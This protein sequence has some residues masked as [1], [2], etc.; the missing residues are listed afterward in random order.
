[1][2]SIDLKSV[3]LTVRYGGVGPRPRKKRVHSKVKTGCATCRTRRV[4]CDETKPACN[5][6]TKGKRECPGYHSNI[7][8]FQP[9]T[10]TSRS[11]SLAASTVRPPP[12]FLPFE[13]AAG[14]TSFQYYFEVT[15]QHLSRFF[16]AMMS[17]SFK[18]K[19]AIA[20][21][22]GVSSTFWQTTFPRLVCAQPIVRQGL[23]AMTVAHRRL[24]DTQVPFTTDPDSLKV[25]VDT[26][27]S[28]R[29]NWN[30]LSVDT[31]LL[32]SMQLAVA[33]L[34]AGPSESG[35]SYLRSGHNIIK[36]RRVEPESFSAH[37]A[38]THI[39][40]FQKAIEL[41]Y[42]AFFC[43]VDRERATVMDGEEY[44]ALNKPVLPAVALY[45]PFESLEQA[46]G[47]LDAIT[48]CGQRLIAADPETVLQEDIDMLHEQA[49]SWLRGFANL[50][51]TLNADPTFTDQ[52]GLVL[53]HIHGLLALIY[54]S[55]PKTE[56]DYDSHTE[57]F[58][59]II[60]LV[61]K[62]LRVANGKV[63]DGALPWG[64]SL[65][66][67]LFI[68]A[69]KCREAHIRAYVHQTFNRLRIMAGPWTSCA[70]YQIASRISRME[71]NLASGLDAWM[72]IPGKDRIR[73]HSIAFACE[74]TIRLR[75]K[76]GQAS[77]RQPL[78]EHKFTIKPCSQQILLNKVSR[79]MV[80][81]LA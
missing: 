2:A 55:V 1:M 64:I 28:L 33:E 14:F 70:A 10:D 58:E 71:F 6:C 22:E 61:K 81:S 79:I 13:D 48:T 4:K 17:P 40:D 51:I 7:W 54:S 49:Q 46:M 35:L 15:Q 76:D 32:V 44:V 69:T 57:T 11:D 42:G 41:M 36:Q 56:L 5:Q 77:G 12:S 75:Y 67:P 25:H 21:A 78:Q 74:T 43:K 60:R 73:V 68:V 53:I 72:R 19:A 31:I 8:L 39:E 9:R 3:Q 80:L 47:G 62:Y 18:G 37:S 20:E 66:N 45:L 26:L 52:S 23:L 29:K 16:A 27:T 30:T 34:A 59:R 65:V 63:H 38:E 50:E 24:E